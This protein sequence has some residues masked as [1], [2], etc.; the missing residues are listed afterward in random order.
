MNIDNVKTKNLI[1]SASTDPVEDKKMLIHYVKELQ[2]TKIDFLHCD[3]MDGIFVPEI[4]FNHNFVKLISANTVLPLNVHLMVENPT[5]YIDDYVSAGANII[6]VHYEAFPTRN[7]LLKCLKKIKKHGCFVEVAINPTT[8]VN[9]IVDFLGMC[10]IILVMSVFPGQSGQAFLP[11]TL[12]KLK[13]LSE[14]RKQFKFNFKIEVDGGVNPNIIPK[15]KEFGVDMVCSGSY[16]FNS[17]DRVR[18]IR[19]LR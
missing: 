18:D 17:T 9:N 11:E 16:I 3:V 6:T 2:N 12:L 15:L 8:E 1:V 5:K 4:T 14:V 13:I 10:D 19:K 7:A